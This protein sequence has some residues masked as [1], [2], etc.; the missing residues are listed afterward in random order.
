M[1]IVL[2]DTFIVPEDSKAKLMEEV[3]RSATF[4]RTLPGFAEGFATRKPTARA[5]TT[6]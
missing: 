1:E 4:L 5:A 2:I 3:R 6:S